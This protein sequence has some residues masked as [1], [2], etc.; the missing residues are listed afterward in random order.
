MHRPEQVHR[1][2][3]LLQ[4]ASHSGCLSSGVNSGNLDARGTDLAELL[5]ILFGHS[6]TDTK[7]SGTENVV[8]SV[9][10]ASHE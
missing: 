3:W 1:V 7:V 2:E 5:A 8:P 6:L 9:F 10:M 4:V